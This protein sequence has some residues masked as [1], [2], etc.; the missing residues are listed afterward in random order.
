MTVTEGMDR[1]YSDSA[2][3][4]ARARLA[5]GFSTAPVPWFTWV[6][7]HLEVFPG[8]RL[9][10]VGCGPAWFWPEAVSVLAED[11]HLTLFDQSPGMV[12]EA[13]ARCRPLPFASVN[14]QV[15]DAAR[16]P[17]EDESF[18]ALIAM[19][20]LYHVK[21]QAGAIAEFHRVLKPGGS[22]LVTTNGLAN[23]QELYAMT[24]VFGG[25]PRDPGAEAFG[26]DRAQ[27]LLEARFGN[28]ELQVHPSVM[29]VTD[30][31]VVFLALTSYPPGDTAP[32]EQQSAFRARL[33]AAFEK[34][35]GGMDVTQQVGLV[36]SRK[37]L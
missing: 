17:F 37:A 33:E 16:L 25:G 5:G 18:D 20:M 2:K 35:R 14:G 24:T 22:L 21:D 34:G 23:L 26:L 3:L 11:L 10:D 8:A 6:A 9:L 27:E 15:G 31:E 12:A 7:Q 1:Q 13:E 32:P 29:H 30:P 19:H 28:A 4:A 36:L